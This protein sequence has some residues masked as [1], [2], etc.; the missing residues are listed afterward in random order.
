MSSCTSP[1]V[2]VLTTLFDRSENFSGYCDRIAS[3]TYPNIRLIVIDHGSHALVDTGLVIPDFCTVLRSS[4]SKWWTGAINDGLRFVLA[5]P[6]LSDDD[7]VLLQNDDV[8][9]DSDFVSALVQASAGENAVVGAITV[10][11]DTGEVVD[12]D[13]TLDI[14]RAKHVC[15]RRGMQLSELAVQLFP[16]DILKGRGVIYPML[17]VNKIGL[18]DERLNRRS[19]PEWAY[20]AKRM[21]CPVYVASHIVAETKVDTD[22]KIGVSA[23]YADI[24]RY[25]FSPRSTANLPDAWIYFT[26]CLGPVRGVY[27]FIVHTIRSVAYVHYRYVVTRRFGGS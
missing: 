19:D 1:T 21:G 15:V 2:W 9:F 14:L 25:L 11:I 24:K 5:Q 10:D 4:P 20:R 26:K 23:E 6:D 3:Q 17:V 27:C 8:R 16:T 22:V 13:N 7:F 12:A 18:L